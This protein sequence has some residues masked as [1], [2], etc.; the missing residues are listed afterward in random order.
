[1][2]DSV[3]TGV[4]LAASMANEVKASRVG[5]LIGL[6]PRR[7]PCAARGSRFTLPAPALV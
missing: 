7:R 5:R 6:T 1:M 4:Q 2:L 3:N